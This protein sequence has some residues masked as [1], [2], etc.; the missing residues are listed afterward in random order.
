MAQIAPDRRS[1][2]PISFTLDILGDKW[3]LLVIRDLVFAHKR[4]FRDFLA[5]DEKIATNILAQ[6]LKTL[7]ASGIVS[8]RADPENARKVIYALTNKGINLLPVLL[9]LI[10][11]GATYDPQTAAPKAFIKRL[12]KDREGLIAEIGAMLRKEAQQ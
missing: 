12:A 3:T 4:N 11:W 7:E 9:E 2:C 1:F 8:R 6:R 10:R 5:S